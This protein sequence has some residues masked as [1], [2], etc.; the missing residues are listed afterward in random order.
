MIIYIAFGD[1]CLIIKNQMSMA[2][3]IGAYKEENMEGARV[4]QRFQLLFPAM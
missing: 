2:M 4:G 3:A 1:N